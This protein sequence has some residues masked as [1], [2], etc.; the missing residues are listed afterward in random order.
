MQFQLTE[1]QRLIQ[2]TAR[3]IAK[4]KIAPPGRRN[5]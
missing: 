5:R 3:R 1:E 4:E 2:E